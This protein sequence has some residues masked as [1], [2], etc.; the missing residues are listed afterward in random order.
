[1][2]TFKTEWAAQIICPYCGHK[3]QEPE[4]VNYLDDRRRDVCCEECDRE[5][6]YAPNMRVTFSTYKKRGAV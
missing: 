3:N 2:T 4:D 6:E 1:M 5:F